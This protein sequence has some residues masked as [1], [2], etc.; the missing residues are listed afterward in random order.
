MKNVTSW[1]E[2]PPIL[3][4]EGF[5]SRECRTLDS[6]GMNVAESAMAEM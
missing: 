5:R 1:P 4:T 2:F 6:D 3:K